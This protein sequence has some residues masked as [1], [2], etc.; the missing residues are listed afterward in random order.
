MRTGPGPLARGVVTSPPSCHLPTLTVQ[1]PLTE[2]GTRGAVQPCVQSADPQGSRPF[3]YLAAATFSERRKCLR[4]TVLIPPETRLPLANLQ[5]SRTSWLA[6]QRWRRGSRTR[7]VRAGAVAAVY[8]AR[9]TGMSPV[10]FSGLTPEVLLRPL[11]SRTC[12]AHL[13][14]SQLTIGR[15]KLGMRRAFGFAG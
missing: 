12:R 4:S 1:F 10:K 15:K 5:V 13:P 3:L 6:I 2:T 7:G 14:V 8:P 11:R 9:N